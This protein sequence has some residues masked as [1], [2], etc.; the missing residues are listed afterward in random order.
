MHYPGSGYPGV[1]NMFLFGHSTNW[2]YVRNQAYK[3]FNNIQN[4]EKGDVVE[5]YTDNAKYLYR[6]LSVRL[7]DDSEVLVDFDGGKDML[8]IST[9]N[10]FGE[11][12]E[13][14]VV[15]ADFVRKVPI[16]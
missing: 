4:L 1:G 7:A 2:K 11:K 6:V 13:R 14:F 5:V 9:C 15:E 10:T 16:E 12:Q 3:T 8:T